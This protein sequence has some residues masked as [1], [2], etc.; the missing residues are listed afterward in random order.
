MIK[1]FEDL[2]IWQDGRALTKAVY[3]VTKKGEFSKDFAL[4]DQI[5]R[6]AFSIPS[7]IAE[8]FDRGSNKQ[9]HHFLSI[10]KGSAGEVRSLLYTALDQAYIDEP[11]FQ[12]LHSQALRT[13]NKIGA[14]MHYLRKS[15]FKGIFHK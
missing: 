6:A 4:K 3:A 9:F 11:E 10:A 12:D 7:N 15:G 8:G 14:L 2:E 13:A 1:R 5:R